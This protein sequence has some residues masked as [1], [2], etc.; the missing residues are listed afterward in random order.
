MLATKIYKN[1]MFVLT[2]IQALLQ[3]LLIKILYFVINHCKQLIYLTYGFG[4]GHFYCF[5]K[6]VHNKFD[7]KR[8]ILKQL[9]NICKLYLSNF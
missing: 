1:Y 8:N 5:P 4:F 6:L 3:T 7:Q 9:S 2:L